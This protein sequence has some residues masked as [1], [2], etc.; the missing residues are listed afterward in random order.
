MSN[1][2]KPPEDILEPTVPI[3]RMKATKKIEFAQTVKIPRSL[4]AALAMSSDR[5]DLIANLSRMVGGDKLVLPLANNEKI[6]LELALKDVLE[7]GC[8]PEEFPQ[9]IKEEPA[10]LAKL[11][12][13][14]RIV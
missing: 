8:A 3:E 10:L 11:T 7:S 2:D 4:D 9:W 1:F 13:W 12:E 5:D 6:P 14:S